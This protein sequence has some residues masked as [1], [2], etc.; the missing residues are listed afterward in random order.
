MGCLLAAGCSQ[1]GGTPDDGARIRILPRIE[2]RAADTNFA[3]DDRIGL[4]VAQAGEARFE[5]EPLTFDGRLFSAAGRSWEAADTEQPAVFMAYAPYQA[6]G[7][8]FRFSISTD[9]RGGCG[10]SDLLGSILP[11]LFPSFNPIEMLFY[12]I[13]AQL[14]IRIDNRS[15]RAISE[16]IVGGFVPEANIDFWTLSAV[17]VAGMP[18]SDVYAYCA[19]PDE[20]Y[21]VILVPQRADLTVRIQTDDGAVRTRTVPNAPLV[22][23]EA[24]ELRVTLREDAQLDLALNGTIV[25]WNSSGEIGDDGNG[26]GTGE[27]DPSTVLIYEGETYRI[28]TINGKTWMAE[29]LRYIPD[30]ARYMDDYWYP[31]YNIKNVPSLGILYAFPMAVRRSI[32]GVNSSK[33]VQGICPDGWRIPTSSELLELSQNVPLEFFDHAGY[34]QPI[35][36][37]D[38]APPSYST[39]RDYLISA[40]LPQS[41]R[42]NYL[43]TQWYS[44]VTIDVASLPVER[45]AAALRCVKD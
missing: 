42:V 12:H 45:I 26:D 34:F 6:S 29:N 8:P 44:T 7:F 31:D 21:R 37:R 10:P 5:N 2:A 13:L 35:D 43:R 25:D 30:D 36:D 20:A 16:V 17:A 39:V 28:Q 24:Y 18:A 33:P 38:Y 22:Y 4:T 41:G 11:G 19:V 1:E 15:G 9:Q 3:C 27:A 23:G 40:T 14:D 32:P